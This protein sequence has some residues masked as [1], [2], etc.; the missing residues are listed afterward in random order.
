MPSTFKVSLIEH[1]VCIAEGRA[2]SIPQAIRWAESIL[3]DKTERAFIS[4]C[5]QWWAQYR[6][7]KW[8]R[9]DASFKP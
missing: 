1:G 5:G 9:R 3:T 2:R 4:A 6:N 7:G 8:E